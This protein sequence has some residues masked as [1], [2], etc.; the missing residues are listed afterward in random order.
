[1]ATRASL[2][3][4]LSAA[5]RFDESERLWRDLLERMRR[6]LGRDHPDTAN[7]LVGL[8]EVE[9]HRGRRDAALGMLEEAVRVDPRW[10]SSLAARKELKSLAGDPAFKEL[11]APGTRK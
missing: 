8:A 3:T 5:G 7:C 11:V 9:A 2:A 4:M 10:A 1:M 6:V